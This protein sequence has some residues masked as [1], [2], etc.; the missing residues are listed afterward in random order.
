M[1]QNFTRASPARDSQVTL[2]RSGS[3]PLT[4]VGTLLAK[5]DGPAEEKKIVRW[6]QLKLYHAASGV[7]VVAIQFR[8]TSRHETTWDDAFVC[9][10]SE[11]VIALLEDYDPVEYVLGWPV[12]RYADKDRRVRDVLVADFESLVST[13][14][15]G[16]E[17][18]AERV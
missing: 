13:L 4:F 2:Q 10:T 1:T 8:T 14:L 16:L 18:F 11:D 7:Y 9:D 12:P 17:E 5:A 6:H 15:A 3:R